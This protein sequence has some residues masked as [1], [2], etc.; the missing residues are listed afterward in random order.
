MINQ[1]S[2]RHAGVKQG[3]TLIELLVVIAMIAILAAIL[4]PALNSARERGRVASCINNLKQLGTSLTT[5]AD[6]NDGIYVNGYSS[7]PYR[8]FVYIG[9]G[10]SV[11]IFKCPSSTVAPINDRLFEQAVTGYADKYPGSYGIN[12]LVGATEANWVTNGYAMRNQSSVKNPTQTPAFIEVHRTDKVLPH[13][14]FDTRNQDYSISTRHN[15]NVNITW[16]DGHV[17]PLTLTQMINESTA[18]GSSDPV[19]KWLRGLRN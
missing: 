2:L 19:Y 11:D 10:L 15:E 17:A 16:I 12:P 13:V 5:Y 14:T 9:T 4:L 3:F 8:W 18:L 1:K 6:G 7:A